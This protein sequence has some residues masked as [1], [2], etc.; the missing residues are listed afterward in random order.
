MQFK[1]IEYVLAVGE[2]ENFTK[3][4][5]SLFVSQPAVS[6]AVSSLEKELK[7]Q[8]FTK[9]DGRVIYTDAGRIF[10]GYGKII[11]AT[12]GELLN[13]MEDIRLSRIGKVCLGLSPFYSNVFMADI[14]TQFSDKYP[15]VE[16]NVLGLHSEGLLEAA[17]ADKLDMIMTSM[18]IS[19]DV[20]DSVSLFD[21]YLIVVMNENDPLC[22]EFTRNN[23]HVLDPDS[24]KRLDGQDYVSTPAGRNLTAYIS[25]LFHQMSIA[26]HKTVE[27]P[28]T[29]TA[30][31][32]VELGSGFAIQPMWVAASEHSSGVLRFFYI[33]HPAAKRTMKLYYRHGKLKKYEEMLREIVVTTCN[34]H[35]EQFRS[36]FP[37][38]F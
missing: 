8:L 26:P 34:E 19:N 11:L 22:R 1:D 17:S 12:R 38:Y 30:I 13:K 24:L 9:Q 28:S 35:F 23:K 6:K 16:L 18:Q 33:D 5:E 15:E 2:K 32:L 31:K 14:I 36:L 25:E 27:S 3:A 29:E 20:M 37:H 4:A 21:E 10:A 7:I